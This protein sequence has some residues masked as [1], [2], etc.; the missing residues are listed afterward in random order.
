MERPPPRSHRRRRSWRITGYWILTLSAVLTVAAGT[1]IVWRW[2]AAGTGTRGDAGCPSALLRVAAAPEIANV[3]QEAS[4]ALN[5]GNAICGPVYVTAREPAAVAAGLRTEHPDVWIPSSSAWLRFAAVNGAVFEAPRQVVASSPLVVV[6]PAGL[7]TALWPDRRTG[8]ADVVTKVNKKQIKTVNV[9][10]PLRDTAGLLTVLG[11]HTAMAGT[12]TDPG[13][14][15]MRALSLRNRLAGSGLAA[16]L[17]A[18][19]AQEID[20]AAA[21]ERIGV[22]TATEQALAAYREQSP[23]VALEGL[24]PGDGAWHADYPFVAAKEVTADPGREDLVG[25]LGALLSGEEAQRALADAGF[26]PGAPPGVGAMPIPEDPERV[27]TTATQWSQYRLLRFQVLILVDGSGS[28]NSPVTTADGRKT[29]KADLLRDSGANAIPLF[30]ED[31]SLGLWYFGTASATGAPYVEAVPFGPLDEKLGET[32]RRTV[33]NQQIAGYKP[34]ENAGTP[35]YQTV[36]DGVRT[37]KSKAKPDVVSMVVVLTDGSDEGSRFAMPR[38]TFLSQLAAE[39]GDLR[40]VPVFT[41]GYG[42][43]ADVATL[44]AMSEASGGQVVMA[45][46]TIDVATAIAKVFLAAHTATR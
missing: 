3:V 38:E 32:D 28:M 35:L 19:Y 13:I 27:I 16:D 23:P 34:Q 45:T 26:R 43:D 42:P 4:R 40:P 29:T 1:T 17:F 36:L 31:T 18:R 11:V 46:R 39:E 41:I 21:G 7:S 20:P 33:L 12:T 2:N 37:M 14:A 22:F 44:K 6:A 9:A 10:D 30:G 15:Q 24:A 25:R 8:W 5:P